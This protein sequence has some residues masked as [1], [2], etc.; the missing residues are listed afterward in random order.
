MITDPQISARSEQP[1]VGIRTLVT[2]EEFGQGVIP[3]RADPLTG[4]VPPEQADRT[5]AKMRE[6]ITAMVPTLPS[7]GEYLRHLSARGAR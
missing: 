6:S 5:M 2:M 3:R 7:Q 1:T 4:A